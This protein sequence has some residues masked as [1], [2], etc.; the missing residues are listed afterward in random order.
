METLI[1]EA[2]LKD[3]VKQALLELL[4]E[5]EDA[6]R[7]LFT[8]VVEDIA[9]ANAIREGEGTERVG[10]QEILDVLGTKA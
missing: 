4:Q 2:R 6:L 3:L 10:K 7:D 8:E 1:D 9:L 5:R